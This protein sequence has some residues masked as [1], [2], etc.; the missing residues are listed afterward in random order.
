LAPL[1][2]IPR[3][4]LTILVTIGC[5]LPLAIV[6]CLGV[7]RLLAAMQDEAAAIALDRVALAA[8]IVWAIDLLCLLL[9]IG[10]NALGPPPPGSGDAS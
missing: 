10:I 7:G 2:V 5:V 3:S 6:V 8:A 4:L 9:A 1:D